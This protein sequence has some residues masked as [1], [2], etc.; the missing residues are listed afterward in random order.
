M[1]EARGGSDLGATVETVA[2]RASSFGVSEGL[3]NERWLL[4]GDKY[5]CS[6][7]GAELAVVAARPDDAPERSVRGL[8]LFLVPR[9]PRRWITQLHHPTAQGQDRYPLCADGRSRTARE[10]SLPAR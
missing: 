7:A 3:A 8:A 1:T 10:R 4:T 5:F 6:N 2:R 9:L